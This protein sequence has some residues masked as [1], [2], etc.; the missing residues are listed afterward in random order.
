MQCKD[1]A[2]F[3]K[4]KEITPKMCIVYP[5]NLEIDAYNQ[6]RKEIGELE[7]PKPD[8][9]RLVEVMRDTGAP[10]GLPLSLS[11]DLADA[12]IKELEKK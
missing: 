1:L 6:A 3:P 4:E 2:G 10:S 5:K 12:I 9:D 7:I 8:R 11:N